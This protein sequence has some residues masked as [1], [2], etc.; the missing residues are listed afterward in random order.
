[1]GIEK[2]V[3]EYIEE[4]TELNGWPDMNESELTRRATEFLDR[5]NLLHS[6]VEH[7]QRH[8]DAIS[9]AEFGLVE[10]QRRGGA[11]ELTTQPSGRTLALHQDHR[12]ICLLDR[13]EDPTRG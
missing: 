5:R 7:R 12:K 11:F 3:G 1:M 4:M 9:R 6:K 8:S 13:S 10:S 2:I